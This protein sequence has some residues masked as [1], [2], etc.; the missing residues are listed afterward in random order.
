LSLSTYT[1]LKAAL[2]NTL[3]RSDL[4]GSIPDF[5]TLAEDKLNKRLRLRAME[6]RVTSSISTEY[7]ALPTGFLSIRNIQLNTNPK[8]RLEYVTPDFIDKNYGGSATGKPVFYT[9]VGGEV[10]LAP[11]PDGT[12]TM[13]MSYFKKLDLATDETNTVLTNAPRV[14]YYG[15]L[16]EAAAYMKEDRR[17]PLWAQLFEQ[18]INELEG[19]DKNDRLPMGGGLQMRVG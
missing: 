16:M 19:A 15:S 3:H 8:V 12:Y 9:I 2:A 18:A 13:E 17:V 14:Y 7:V 4:T 5:I 11:A 1:T 10:Q 6:N